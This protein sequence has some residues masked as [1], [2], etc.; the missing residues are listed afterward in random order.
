MNE[1]HLA[2]Q[3][4]FISDQ[5]ATDDQFEAF[6]DEVVRQL[7]NIGCEVNLAARLAERMAEF[8]TAI[9]AADF[10]TAATTFLANLRTA[11]HA[12]GCITADWPKFE[13][14]QHVVSELQDA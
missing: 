7:D 2:V 1:I 10:A 13:A 3:T 8:A 4:M 5:P 14:S 12:A 11:L 9:S 6:L